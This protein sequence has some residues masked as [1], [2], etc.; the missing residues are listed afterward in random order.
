MFFLLSD[1]NMLCLLFA[2]VQLSF[3]S[4]A[5]VFTVLRSSRRILARTNFFLFSRARGVVLQKTYLCRSTITVVCRNRKVCKA[6]EN[7]MCHFGHL[8]ALF[9]LK[10][11]FVETKLCSFASFFKS[12]FFDEWMSRQLHKVYGKL[13]TTLLFR[14]IRRIAVAFLS[15]A[16]KPSYGFYRTLFRELYKLL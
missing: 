4:T 3:Y 13:S 9:D 5:R 2:T 16:V 1:E 10:S 7:S 15:H 8:I 12:I 6:I 11:F 14:F